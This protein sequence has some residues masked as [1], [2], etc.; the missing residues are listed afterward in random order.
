M[1]RLHVF[2]SVFI[3]VV[4]DIDLSIA[5]VK[6]VRYARMHL[7]VLTSALCV[8]IVSAMASAEAAPYRN[9]PTCFEVGMVVLFYRRNVSAC[10]LRYKPSS[11]S[12]FLENEVL[13]GQT[14][15][16]IKQ[17]TEWSQVATPLRPH[18]PLGW[19]RSRYLLPFS[20]GSVFLL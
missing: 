15:L 8:V 11:D 6:A 14:L 17:T 5:F 18:E 7:R 16:I 12:D 9:P 10:K 3:F 4:D 13:V 1:V 2:C 19:L 20:C